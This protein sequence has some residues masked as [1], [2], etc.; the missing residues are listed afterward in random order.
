MSQAVIIS[1]W[2]VVHED[3]GSAGP[4]PVLPLT[5]SSQPGWPDQPEHAPGLGTAT[6]GPLW[7]WADR[8]DRV[9]HVARAAGTDAAVGKAPPAHWHGLRPLGASGAAYLFELPRTPVPPTALAPLAQPVPSTPARAPW[10]VVLPMAPA[11]LRAMS[12]AASHA[13]RDASEVWAEAAREWLAR[14]LEDD[15]EPP[16]P[17][18]SAPAKTAERDQHQRC[19][20]AIDVLLGDLRAPL[21]TTEDEPAA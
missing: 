7:A 4:L 17:G 9:D 20:A 14:H 15:P 1:D 3:A 12:L 6:A 10:P 13:R 16:T 21:P 19:W 2:Y 8:V 5:R 18:A 11:L